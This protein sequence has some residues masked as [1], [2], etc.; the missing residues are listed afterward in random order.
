MS[1]EIGNAAEYP[2]PDEAHTHTANRQGN[3]YHIL[4]FSEIRKELHPPPRAPNPGWFGHY[5]SLI[6]NQGQCNTTLAV[7]STPTPPWPVPSTPTSQRRFT[8]SKVPK[9][10]T[11]PATPTHTPVISGVTKTEK[12]LAQRHGPGP[13]IFL[14]STTLHR[15]TAVPGLGRSVPDRP[16]RTQCQ[17]EPCHSGC[18]PRKVWMA[19]QGLPQGDGVALPRN[20]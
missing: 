13:E 15:R 14:H 11:L 9:T 8:T 20:S 4:I 6:S 18:R 10:Q 12:P 3:V 16:R 5:S 19:F 2:Q 7:P 17:P 1:I